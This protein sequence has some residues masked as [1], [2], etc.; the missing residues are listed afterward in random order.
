MTRKQKA[1]MKEFYEEIDTIEGMEH[2]HSGDV[3][4]PDNVA[5]LENLDQVDYVDDEEEEYSE[6]DIESFLENVNFES[7]DNRL[8]FDEMM[9]ATV[10][11]TGIKFQQKENIVTPH[12]LVIR[13]L[14]ERTPSVCHYKD[15]LYDGA[16]AIGFKNWHK[17][18]KSKQKIA[19]AALQKH[20]VQKHK[21]R[22]N[23]LIDK[24]EIPSSWLSPT[25]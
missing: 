19:L 16:K 9:P 4:M 1:E 7:S 24:A 21:F 14:V 23:E 12:Y 15:C 6:D 18:P 20:N 22:N 5:L 2:T 8:S 25:L 3:D 17:V 11:E 13:E 10:V